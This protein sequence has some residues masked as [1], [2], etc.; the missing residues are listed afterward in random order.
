[1]SKRSEYVTLSLVLVLVLVAHY[2]PDQTT[3]RIKLAVGGLFLPL[4]GL[5]GLV[6]DLAVQVGVTLTPRRTLQAQVSRLHAE[7][8]RLQLQLIQLQE[9]GRE[10]ARLRQALGWQQR[11]PGQLKLAAVTGH[12]PANWWR[13]IHIDLGHRDGVRTNL[14]VLIPEGLVGRVAEVGYA[15]ARVVLVGD[16]A[17]RFSAQAQATREKGIIQPN[18]ASLDP[19]LVDFTLVPLGAS[20]QPSQGVVTSGDGGIF[21]K[22][23]PVGQ[24]VDVH[25]NAS[26]LYL[27]ARVK[28]AANLDRLEEV[29]VLWP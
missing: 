3:S 12:D 15:R 1:M 4:F 29:W 19:L 9:A 23:I 2:L 24:I 21:P 7:N 5:A 10:N 8:Q 25:T 17:C 27:D 14:P 22:G 11:A 18:A 16:P 20:L 6:E 28:L 13:S 26:G